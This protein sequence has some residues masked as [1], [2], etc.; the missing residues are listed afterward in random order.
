M[1][2]ILNP[3]VPVR[4]HNFFD[5]LGLLCRPLIPQDDR[6]EVESDAPAS[7]CLKHTC[8]HPYCN[9]YPLPLSLAAGDM[10]KQ[11]GYLDLA[12]LIFI[13]SQKGGAYT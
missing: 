3:Q 10:G 1:N 8:N 5:L 11:L 2:F 4:G 7:S 6:W 12:T 9:S 13:S